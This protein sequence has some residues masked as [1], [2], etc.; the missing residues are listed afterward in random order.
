[1]TDIQHMP[2]QIL[3]EYLSKDLAPIRL[4]ELGVE[5]LEANGVEPDMYE[6]PFRIGIE[7]KPSKA[8]NLFYEYKQYSVPLPDGLM[9]HLR[10]EN[11]VIPLKKTVSK[12][13]HPMMKG[14]MEIVIGGVLYLA[15]AYI[16]QTKEP[17]YVS[18]VAHKK[19]VKTVKKTPTGG[20]F[21]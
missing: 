11:A 3:L 1:M 16:S 21:V 7:H 19:P 2:E 4:K 14:D 5:F 8:G 10:L 9:T 6:N 13:G 20:K 18:V 17:Y 12:S 15:K